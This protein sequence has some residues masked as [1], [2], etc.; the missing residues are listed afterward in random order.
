MNLQ[1]ETIPMS[2]KVQLCGLCGLGAAA[3]I[4]AFLV[5][6][7]PR[8]DPDPPSSPTG[9]DPWFKDVT[10]SAGLTFTHDTGP[11]DSYFMPQIIGSGAALFDLDNDGR[12]DIYLLQNAGPGSKST[13]RLFR[14]KDDGTFE[15]ISKGSGLDISGHGM[16]VAIGDVNNDGLPDVLVTEYRGIRLFLNNGDRTFTE[17]TKEAGLDTIHWAT[18]ASFVDYD[19]DGWLDLVVVHYVDYDPS[20]RCTGNSGRRDFCHPKLFQPTTARL[21]RNLGKQPG[22]KVAFRDVTV[23]SRLATRP[24]PALGLLCADLNGDGWPDI[25]VANDA[26]PNH[27]WINQKDGTFKEEA[28]Q[29]GC[30]YNAA[31]RAEGN[32]GVAIG[33]IDGKG[34][35]DLFVTHLTEET[36]T[37]WK[38]GPIGFFSD[39]TRPA[40]LVPVRRGTGFGVV[41]GDF[42]NDGHLDLALVNG[43]VARAAGTKSHSFDWADYAE[44]NHLFAGS[45]QGTFRDLSD[46]NTDF[47]GTPRLGRAL[48]AGD[49][50]GQG[51]MDLLAT[52]VNAPAR[53]YRNIA[54]PC[55]HWLIVRAVLPQ[56]K[57]DAYSAVVMVKAGKRQ[58]TRLVQPG[59]SYLSSNDP[60]AHFG[61][62][63]VTEVDSIDVTWPDGAV[64]RFPGGAVDRR[65]TLRQGEGKTVKHKPESSASPS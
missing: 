35:F 59:S 49:I 41:M 37:L 19:R 43:R 29:R 25:F 33:D 51:R 55:G 11:T 5:L 48:C 12:L 7:R 58:W 2:R 53:L 31:G 34:L 64:E 52:Y 6:N 18:S 62:G 17:V 45:S 50:F 20:Q 1:P 57:R 10:E 47:C 28:V 54:E 14:Q 61:L 23:A 56:W 30:A 15:D 24:G 26:W 4:V 16:G 27:L 44:R 36:N 40:N 42:D 8:T 38:Q 63:A 9:P 32:M 65:R 46:A 3:L 60:R 39:R 22:G 21:F 13:N